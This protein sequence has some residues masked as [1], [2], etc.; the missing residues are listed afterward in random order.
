MNHAMRFYAP[1]LVA[2]GI[3]AGCAA[4]S[5]IAPT[6]GVPALVHT[7]SAASSGHSVLYV[8]DDAT[9]AVYTIDPSNIGA[10]PTRK[11]TSGVDRPGAL[12]VDPSGDLYVVNVKNVTV[13][14]PDASTPFRTITSKFGGPSTITISADNT[15]AIT[16]GGGVL[17]S[18]TLVIFDRGSVTPTRTINIP[19]EAQLNNTALF[20]KGVTI[21]SSDNVFL[22]VIR[23]AKGPSAIYEFAH[24]SSHGVAT[25]LSPDTTGGFDSAGNLYEGGTGFICEYAPGGKSCARR[26]TSG[27]ASIG[28][29]AVLPDGTLFVP[30]SV[31][32]GQTTSGEIL[33]Y[34]S[35]VSA[36]SA[37][38][39][40][41]ALSQPI[42]AALGIVP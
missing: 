31:F 41:Q 23:Y 22:S 30:N 10:G 42:G 20:F 37:T 12:A 25:R 6:T 18:G 34:V 36:P 35:G 13:F 11:I 17:K 19:L 16:F 5:G 39:A 38:F 33:M 3:L 7:L 8:S 24:G 9:N 21:D 32:N 14:K 29:F 27:L 40:S 1:A 28:F 2:A 4:P 15:I 26:I